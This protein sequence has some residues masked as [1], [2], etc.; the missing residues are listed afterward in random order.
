VIAAADEQQHEAVM[1]LAD[2]GKLA[3][4]A[5][6]CEA[7]TE[8][9]PLWP[10]GHLLAATIAQSS[11]QPS[12]A[13]IHLKRA[14]YLEP[15]NIDAHLRLGLLLAQTGSRAA[16]IKALRNVMLYGQELKSNEQA[17]VSSTASRLLV[18][19]LREEQT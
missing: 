3:E 8:R 11:G 15:T 9:L 13:I 12:A 14:L 6:Q 1:R 18:Q 5:V 4:A 16:A 19:L 2:A 17:D 10:K 7:L